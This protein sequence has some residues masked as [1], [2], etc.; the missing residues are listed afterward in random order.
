MKNSNEFLSSLKEM[1][2]NIVGVI[3]ERV[4]AIDKDIDENEKAI[5]TAYDN[6]KADRAEM[7]AIT[8]AIFDFAND[9]QG[10]ANDGVD[11]VRSCDTFFADC[12]ELVEDGYIEDEDFEDYD[13]EDEEEEFEDEQIAV[14]EVVNS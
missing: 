2:G 13:E 7:V 14:D 9:V 6:I 4:N 5:Q 8:D 12:T 11:T 10:S 1:F 3:S